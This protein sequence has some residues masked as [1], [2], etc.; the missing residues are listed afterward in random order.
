MVFA[1]GVLS[2]TGLFKVTVVLCSFVS[3]R[4]FSGFGTGTG[5]LGAGEGGAVILGGSTGVVSGTESVCCGPRGTFVGGAGGETGAGAI[6]IAMAAGA[7]GAGR[8]GGVKWVTPHKTTPLTLTT[9]K[10][11]QPQRRVSSRWAFCIWLL[12]QAEKDGAGLF[13]LCMAVGVTGWYRL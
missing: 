8:G 5:G 6:S 1:G 11:E 9:A 10:S 7:S 2:G 12:Y 3:L 4:G 13:W